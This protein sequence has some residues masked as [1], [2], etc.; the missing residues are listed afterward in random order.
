MT[1]YLRGLAEANPGNLCYQKHYYERAY[2]RNLPLLEEKYGEILRKP[3]EEKYADCAAQMA[4][5]LARRYDLNIFNAA[6]PEAAA[7]NYSSARKWLE[8]AEE[9]YPGSS[10]SVASRV[11]ESKR[12][13]D[14]YLAKN[15]KPPTTIGTTNSGAAALGTGSPEENALIS[16][17]N[18]LVSA[19]IPRLQSQQQSLQRKV[20]DYMNANQPARVWMHR[21]IYN[22][23]SGV[24]NSHEAFITL[25]NNLLKRASG[26]SPRLASE[27]QSQI[28]SVESAVNRLREVRYGLVNAL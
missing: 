11:E 10:A 25:L 1:V 6:D 15:Y 13:K 23:A 3:F 21:G 19:N 22:S 2:N 9:V 17:Y 5:A 24:I 27:I 20:A 4:L 18:R 8:K 16:E 7:A 12:K 28:R 14:E 26:T